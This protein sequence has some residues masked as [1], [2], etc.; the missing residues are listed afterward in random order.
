MRSKKRIVILRNLLQAGLDQLGEEYEVRLGGLGSTRE[1][2]L[3]LVGGADAIVA[4]PTV[5]VD[6][7]RKEAPAS[8]EAVAALIGRHPALLEE[9][10]DTVFDAAPGHAADIQVWFRELETWSRARPALKKLDK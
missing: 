4:D 5:P 3:E 6:A 1:D 2:W 8:I 10:L 7:E 9:L